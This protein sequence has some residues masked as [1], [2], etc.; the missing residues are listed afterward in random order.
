MKAFLET[1]RHQNP[2]ASFHFFVREER[3]FDSFR[4]FHPQM[5]LTYIERGRG[6]RYIGDHIHTFVPGDLVLIGKNLPHD[7]VA[8]SAENKDLPKAHVIQFSQELFSALPEYRMLRSL[9]AEALFGL[10]FHAPKASLMHKITSLS[11][12]PSLR[13]LILF[14][15]ILEELNATDNRRKLSTITF[16]QSH[17]QPYKQANIIKI[18]KLI[19]ERYQERI[20]VGEMAREVHMSPSA[21]CRWFKQA[22]GSSFV[23]YLNAVRVE[24]A[25][26]HLL[27]TQDHMK[28]IGF[29]VGFD[30]IAHFN[31]TFKKIKG[32]TPMS[33]R[34][35][36]RE[37]LIR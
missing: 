34:N 27:Q 14:L 32:Q 31:R 12:K 5:E 37:H 1:I 7:Y 19:S 4:H 16:S 30:S 2:T 15:E 18:T 3:Q 8:V 24:K 10:Y 6:I 35:V 11:H 20:T 26:Q 36:R 22:T 29:S 21:F 13:N 25:C 23:T 9:F 17:S 33:Y 28:Q